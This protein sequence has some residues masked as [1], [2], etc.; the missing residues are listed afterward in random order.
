MSGQVYDLGRWKWGWKGIW[1]VMEG[2]SVGWGVLGGIVR[3]GKDVGRER[4]G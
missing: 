3:R 2:E 1:E 4:E